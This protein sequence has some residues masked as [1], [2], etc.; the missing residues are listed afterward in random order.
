MREE[1]Q[2]VLLCL[3]GRP[4]V[5][6]PAARRVKSHT[7]CARMNFAGVSSL[8]SYSLSVH[9]F[10]PESEDT[11]LHLEWYIRSR[12]GMELKTRLSSINEHMCT[13][14]HIH[15]HMYKHI[16]DTLI[17]MHTH[18]NTHT[19]DHAHTCVYTHEHRHNFIKTHTYTY[20]CVC[21]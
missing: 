9:H 6:A 10:L 20:T 11:Q 15:I 5:R 2:G 21:V 19:H 12:P 16:H 18:R 8:W 13:H 17:H 7:Q 14:L 4:E 3:I 1:R